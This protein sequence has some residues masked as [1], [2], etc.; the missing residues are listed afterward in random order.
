[1]PP[2]LRPQQVALWWVHA[3]DVL[4]V[5]LAK[6]HSEQLLA[7]DVVMSDFLIWNLLVSGIHHFFNTVGWYRVMKD[8]SI[9]SGLP[10]C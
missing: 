5:E 7:A 4:R 6:H 8:D 3:D 1:M 10:E 2:L 9:G